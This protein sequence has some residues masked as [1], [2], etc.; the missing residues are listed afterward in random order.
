MARLVLIVWFFVYWMTSFVGTMFLVFILFFFG[1][2][3]DFH[4]TINHLKTETG[5][6]TVSAFWICLVIALV[7]AFKKNKNIAP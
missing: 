6:F 3:F 5:Q 4:Q 1:N 7:L 2:L